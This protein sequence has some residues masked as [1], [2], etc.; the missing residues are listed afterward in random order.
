[1][2]IHVL[3]REQRLPRPPEEVFAFFA[4][5]RNLEAITPPLL[6]FRVVTP[7]PIDMRVGT[8][9]QYRL[10]LHGVPVTWHTSIQYWSPPRRFVDVQVRGPYALWHHTHAFEPVDGGRATRMT[11]TVRYALG[12]GAL[13]ELAHRAL[14]RRDLER[15]FDFRARRVPALVAP[16]ASGRD[17]VEPVEDEVGAGK[18]AR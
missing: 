7:E 11:D 12:L 13:G 9:I 4:D 2:R 1:M 5:A 15:I 10:R 8:F 6:R 18:L 17:G 3:H 14:V 16:P